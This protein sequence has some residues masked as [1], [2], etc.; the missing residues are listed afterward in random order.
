MCEQHHTGS[1]S[2]LPG[3]D[4]TRRPKHVE[5][6]T[7]INPSPPPSL[8]KGGT[9]IIWPMGNDGHVTELFFLSPRSTRRGVEKDERLTVKSSFMD[10]NLATKEDQND[11]GY[12]DTDGFCLLL[13]F[14]ECVRGMAV[15]EWSILAIFMHCRNCQGGC[16]E[17]RKGMACNYCSVPNLSAA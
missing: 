11:Q 15:E 5:Q 14:L 4:F 2:S 9:Y 17:G 1:P 10:I 13:A 16:R 3:I 12:E 8:A 7:T 6:R